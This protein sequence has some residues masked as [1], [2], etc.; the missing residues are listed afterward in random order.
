MVFRISE[1]KYLLH[2]TQL[3]SPAQHS[4]YHF[5]NYFDTC[6]PLGILGGHKKITFTHGLMEIFTDYMLSISLP[7]ARVV[8]GGN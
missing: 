1:E 7:G 5:K 2:Q 6:G 8:C 4:C 3:I